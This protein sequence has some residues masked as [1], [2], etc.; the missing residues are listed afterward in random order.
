MNEEVIVIFLLYVEGNASMISNT[1]DVG[2]LP[3]SLIEIEKKNAEKE[4]HKK[5]EGL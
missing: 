3:T 5:V 2:D 4:A 1:N